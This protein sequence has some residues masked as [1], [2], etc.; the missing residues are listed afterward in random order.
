[1]EITRYDWVVIGSGF[2]GSVSALRPQPMISPA[3]C[4]ALPA[5][6]QGRGKEEW[7]RSAFDIDSF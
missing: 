6:R 1:M 5:N 2:G 4:S 7:S 3:P